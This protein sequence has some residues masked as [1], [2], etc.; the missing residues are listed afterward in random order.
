MHDRRLLLLPGKE[1]EMPAFN[2]IPAREAI[3]LSCAAYPYLLTVIG[4]RIDEGSN[5][6]H[7]VVI[8]AQN[9]ALVCGDSIVHMEYG[10]VV[11][12]KTGRTFAHK[13]TFDEW[14]RAKNPYAIGTPLFEKSTDSGTPPPVEFEPVGSY[15]INMSGSQYKLMTSWHYDD[16]GESFIFQMPGGNRGPKDP[17]IT[18]ITR[19]EF[20]VLA[21]TCRV[22]SIAEVLSQE[23]APETPAEDDDFG[24]LV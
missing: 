22:R 12:L 13:D 1:T 9:V 14:V 17:R 4:F 6:A 2:L 15:A 20:V 5:F 21:K 16:D 11:D 18:K 24:D 7:P 8:G 23:P 19:D 10:E 3:S